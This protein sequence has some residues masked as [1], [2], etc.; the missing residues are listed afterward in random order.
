MYDAPA[1]SPRRSCWPALLPA[2]LGLA[3]FINTAPGQDAPPNRV[4]DLTDG[5]G[6][7]EIGDKGPV[8]GLPF[9]IEAQVFVPGEEHASHE[10]IAGGT[11]DP[12]DFH[13]GFQRSP[14]LYLYHGT[15]V[16]GGYGDGDK[17]NSWGMEEVLA[18]DAW[19]HVALTGDGTV[20]R[21]YVN[22]SEVHSEPC[23][24][25]PVAA[26]LRWIGKMGSRL[27]G[28]VDEVRVWTVPRTAEQIRQA[29]TQRLAGNEDGLTSLWNFDDPAAPGRDAT[30]HGHD[31]ILQDSARVAEDS[32]T[33]APGGFWPALTLDG[34]SA[35]ELPREIFAGLERATVE[36]WVRWDHFGSSQRILSY[37]GLGQ[38]AYFGCRKENIL[39]WVVRDEQRTFLPLYGNSAL[40]PD[41]WHHVAAVSSPQGARLYVDGSE[42]AAD[43]TMK[44][45][46]AGIPPGPAWIGRWNS[47]DATGFAGFEGSLAEFRIWRTARTAEE[48]RLTM[49]QRLAGTEEGLAGLWNFADAGKLAND[50]S[51]AARHGRS[52][53]Q[54]QAT[55][56]QVFESVARGTVSGKVT[57]EKGAPVA[58]AR[59]EM[60]VSGRTVMRDTT[61]ATGAF[62]MKVSLRWNQVTLAATKDG[63][64]AEPQD[65]ILKQGT[66]EPVSLQILRPATLS[67]TVLDT[68]GRPQSGV[69]VEA[70][71][72]L[73][74]RYAATGTD[75]SY[76]FTSLPPGEYKLRAQ[77]EGAPVEFEGGKPLTL[78]PG[79]RQ[80][81]DFLRARRVAKT[82]LPAGTGNVLRLDGAS[83]GL[84]L[85]D[86]FMTSLHIAT[87]E[88]LV[89]WDELKP[90]SAA[91]G[92]GNSS[93]SLSFASLL[94]PEDFALVF[95]LG[96]GAAERIVVPGALRAGKWMHVAA[97]LEGR[98]A[99]IF[100]N[101]V[102]AGT[103]PFFQS[104]NDYMA[105][106][107]MIGS[108][109]RFGGPIPG[110]LDE[111][112]IWAVRR[113]PQQIAAN[114]HTRLH[115]D[116]D[117]L[118][119][120]WSFDDAA[121]PGRDA[122]GRGLDGKPR[123]SLQTAPAP[124]PPVLT[125]PTVVL[126]TVT[127]PDGR[128]VEKADV[129][130]ES[131]GRL[132]P[133]AITDDQGAWLATVPDGIASVSAR[134]AKGDFACAPQ[135][136][137]VKPGENKLDLAL[138]DSAPV[139][140][141]TL[142]MDDSPLPHIVVQAVSLD[143]DTRRGLFGELYRKSNLTSFPDIT[144]GPDMR[145]VDEQFS[146]P[147][148]N[149]SIGGGGMG[150][151]FYARWSGKL[152][153]EA[154]GRYSFHLQANDRARLKVD[155][156]EIA[157]A[158]SRLTG[159][160]PLKDTEKSGTAELTA[161]EHDF[162]V[163]YINRIG[164]QG[165]LLE[166]TPPGG[167]RGA[168]PAA[169]LSHKPT[170]DQLLITT[171]SDVRG[172]YRFPGLAP[173]EYQVRAQVPGGFAMLNNGRSVSAKTG[174]PKPGQNFRLAPFKK[175]VWRHFTFNDGLASD[176]TSTIS[177]APDGA[178]WIGSQAGAS[179]FDGMKFSTLTKA[180]GLADNNVYCTLEEPD[181]TLWLGTMGGLTRREAGTGACTTYDREKGLAG[182]LV[183]QLLRDRAG[184][185]WAS[186]DWGL[187][188]WK[189]GGFETLVRRE[190]F[191]PHG[192]CLFEDS[193]GTVW[194]GDAGAVWRI[195]DG[196]PEKLGAEQLSA[197]G[198]VNAICEDEPGVLWL[199][200]KTGLMRW[201]MDTTEVKHFTAADG[202][203]GAPVVALHRDRSGRIW[204][205]TY[206]GGA[207]MGVSSFEG[208]SF[209]TWRRPDGL[210]A[211]N[212][213][214][215]TGDA[216]G[217]VWFATD[218]GI[219]SLDQYSVTAWSPQDGLDTGSVSQITST[220]DGAVWFVTNNKLSRFDGRQFTKLNQQ[221]GLATGTVDS[222][223]VDQ[224]GS[225]LALRGD[226]PVLRHKPT[227]GDAAPV[228]EPE[229]EAPER[230]RAAARGPDGVM[231]Y[232]S[233]P[234]VWREGAPGPSG[235]GLIGPVKSM[236]AAA[237]GSM[238]FEM[239]EKSIRRFKDGMFAEYSLRGGAPWGFLAAPDGRVYAASWLGPELFDG[240][241]F[242][243]WPADRSRLSGLSV[244]GFAQRPG[245]HLRIAT[246]QGLYSH[247]G[248]AF[249][250]LDERDGLPESRFRTV[251]ETAGG[252]VWL[253]HERSSGLIR[254][255]PLQRPPG[256][257]VV[258]ILTGRRQVERESPLR[259]FAHQ[260]AT[261]K[262]DAVDLR[263][264]PAKRQYRWQLYQG[265]RDEKSLAAGWSPPGTL[266]ELEQAFDKPGAWTLA[267]QYLDRD[268]NYSPP[269]FVPLRVVIPWHENMAV[270]IPAGAGVAG[271][272]GWALIARL[273]YVRKRRE[274]EKLREQMLQQ[275]H[276]AR[277]A[278]EAQNE[279]LHLAREA[280]DD[281]NKAKSQ[282]LAN[283][284]H[285]L[286]TPMNA[287][288]GYSEMLQEE[289]QDLGQDSFLPDLQKIHGAGKH[290]L[291]LINDI[292]DLSKVEAGKMSLFLEEFDVATMVHE[293]AA[294]VQPL[295][296][297]KGNRL[298]VECPQDVGTMRADV[299]KV[300]QTLFNL[301]SNAGKFT[302]Q[303]TI[304]LEVR[305]Q[306]SGVSRPDSG[307]A[308]PISDLRPPTSV[309]FRVS[310]TG[311]GIS[312]EAQSRLFEAFT[313][314][315]ASTTR[316]YGG[317]GLGLAIS[318]KFC[319]MMGGDIT[320][321]S[322][323]GKGTVFTVVLPQEVKEQ[324]VV[325]DNPPVPAA[326]G[327]SAGDRRAVVL[328]IDDDPGARDI[329][330]RHLAKEG[331]ATLTAASGEEGLALARTQK[332][333]VIALD[334]MMPGMDGWAVLTALKADPA[335]AGIP[336]IVTT[337]VDNR[338][339][340]FALG[341][342]DYFTK[343]L[344]WPRFSS[345]VQKLCQTPERTVLIV[346][347][348]LT[349][350]DMLRRNMEKDG[351]TVREAANGREGLAALAASVP[352]LV[353]LDLMM[354]EMDGFEFMEAL[355]LRNDARHIP[356]IVITAKDLTGEDRRRLNGQVERII[357]KGRHTPADIIS[358]IRA[359]L[360]KA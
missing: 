166:W 49:K 270:M 280:A 251:H 334:V 142:A 139:S 107:G 61:D 345:V 224:D 113:T 278:L 183:K 37:G 79:A 235:D 32:V 237:D 80:S 293:V 216:D 326:S 249:T 210:P 48:I 132:L 54:P 126:G 57:D 184:V 321:E 213:S 279:Q 101:G 119:A 41:A 287:I 346:E 178:L 34:I 26:P 190:A 196:Q 299:T 87:I 30:G 56:A 201:S 64:A 214:G 133:S 262:F 24:A 277:Q 296:A 177:C 295:V 116:E 281:A 236:S 239:T 313:Q 301:L 47:N 354:P 121:N 25:Q 225:L 85:P 360:P 267:V 38:D 86:G 77:A 349:T 46:L 33:I 215:I 17:W 92:F 255:R 338:N 297:Q 335:T 339:L 96:S 309:L 193:A 76:R 141:R 123:N 75:G 74:V 12:E 357:E 144:A 232:A 325:P 9:T 324:A 62:S 180:D 258:T 179:R 111:V 350:R 351:W 95:D 329:L 155:G 163:E 135:P 136:L 217:V 300:R 244:N 294:T 98:E 227:G 221:N 245:G 143:R 322:E 307:I 194:W 66:F 268:L 88:L 68:E 149:G 291:G 168:I 102:R 191:T 288:I 130:L 51:A 109:G 269:S 290:L 103:G 247:D 253:A 114:I 4:L 104:F 161:G 289:A 252:E 220:R 145:R 23:T 347:D 311:I 39:E 21:V 147:L 84:E 355:R 81:A 230:V 100:I 97:V 206:S 298:I 344:D 337:I 105:G 197:A 226:A 153:I 169:A 263:T 15:G 222:L 172:G 330:E 185:L 112:R 246:I 31:G 348:D 231:W 318:R 203:A 312:R 315:D 146:Y 320:V 44:Q 151:G 317:T 303:G 276:A 259:L 148:V 233:E 340:G 284:S 35:I 43:A 242:R 327:V 272:L 129:F 29:M 265:E 117:G 356:V 13:A 150:D 156:M 45:T 331:L 5:G 50:A 266:T 271:L 7:L 352:S 137:A 250:T 22:G 90:L 20:Q 181:G 91:L 200:T 198:D 138:R 256:A 333:A 176:V 18:V 304:R 342:A 204:C 8:I 128:V 273:M 240:E 27:H 19:N 189:D 72:G 171:T 158:H 154:A 69:I 205:G 122:T 175:G 127:D 152:K 359:L 234:G 42:V 2:A 286:R 328:I 275:E 218:R 314:A 319:Q 332:P 170:E 124:P 186:C 323:P 40:E 157:D 219:A 134:A 195:R 55:V 52:L 70:A 73:K 316:K 212:V 209:V 16:H 188:R 292:L 211:E 118:L 336:V 305:T 243:T 260:R 341:A 257:P 11:V 83:A 167:A 343:P 192:A 14:T 358:E 164:R 106:G 82:P 282:F 78:E 182:R 199:G 238:W 67:G 353:L 254:Y 264:V 110:E 229:P 207:G 285:E 223:T 36:A 162:V 248:T 165:L 63:V 60:T 308:Q 120:L 10:G 65:V 160:T 131:D 261:F 6:H 283:M 174:E 228:F 115:G 125:P 59:V 58:G 173:G 3:I 99:T 140:G 310:D 302:E 274:S 108:A 93:R 208:G 202:L 28:K 53:G 159:S 241:R 71:A 187:S 94:V 1:R 89:K 306:K